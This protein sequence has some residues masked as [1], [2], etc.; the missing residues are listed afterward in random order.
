[1]MLPRI[2]F[3]NFEISFFRNHEESFGPIV[4]ARYTEYRHTEAKSLFQ[5]QVPK[6]LLGFGYK[7]LVFV[8]NGR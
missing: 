6:K 5:I 7:G 4:L 2:R 3:P 1:M 8:E